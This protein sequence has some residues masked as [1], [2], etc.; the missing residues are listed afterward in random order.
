MIFK[1]VTALSNNV[2]IEIQDTGSIVRVYTNYVLITDFFIGDNIKIGN[3]VMVAITTG[4]NNIGIGSLA[5]NKNTTGNSNIAFGIAALNKN[6][7]GNYNIALGDFAL[8]NNINGLSNLAL[9]KNAGRLKA[10]LNYCV[11]IGEEAN[12]LGGSDINSIVLG[13]Q[14]VGVGSNT[15]VIGNGNIIKTILKGAIGV[16]TTSPA[17]SAILDL[18]STT[19]GILIPRMTTTQR[20]AITSPATGLLIYNTTTGQ[21]EYWNGAAWVGLSVLT[22]SAVKGDSDISDAISK[23][24]APHSDDQNLSGL[25]EKSKVSGGITGKVLAKKSDDDYDFIW[26]DS[27]KSIDGGSA[28]S[29]YL[30]T[31]IIDGGNA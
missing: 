15:V 14:A 26:Q 8:I 11:L 27:I 16:G 28:D 18:V 10:A 5:L 23:K 12:T 1:K 21:Y 6:V 22:L 17:A 30:L 4:I 31:Q 29:V 7:G 9:G 24:H 20:N 19:K 25:L 13:Y 3:G 2:L